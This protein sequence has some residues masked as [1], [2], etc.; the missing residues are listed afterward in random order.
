M[1]EI[2]DFT[3]NHIE[4]AM[5]IAQTNYEEERLHV[6]VLPIVD[7]LPDLTEF[8]KNG[9]GAAAFENGEMLGFLCCYSPWN[10]A[11]G[12]TATKG[13]FSPIHAHGA[14]TANREILYKRLYAAAAEKWVKSGIGSHAIGLYAHDVQAV[15]GFFTYGFGLRCVDAI[16]DMESIPGVCNTDYV[17]SELKKE[18]VEN[19][20]PLRRLLSEHLGNSPCFMASTPQDVEAWIQRAV[21]R[22][23][24]IFVSRQNDTVIAFIEV[25]DNGENFACDDSSMKNICGAFCLPEHRGKGVY[26]SLLN[27]M[28]TTLKSEGYSRL[29][30]DFES[31]NPTAAGFW[32]KYFTAYTNSV[33]RRID[34]K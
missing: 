32:L 17:Y 33:V 12:T 29:G 30:V 11:F 10:H 27:C 7:T 24:R 15:H 1:I 26:Q 25:M 21:G 14:L 34:G 3:F 28:I 8:A 20:T 16:R 23:S 22:N 13:T 9:L 2:T 19:I 31:F 5:R 4:Q 18:N 6:P